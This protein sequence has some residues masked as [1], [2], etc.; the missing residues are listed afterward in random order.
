MG[1]ILI[2]LLCWRNLL[3]L[4]RLLM[5]DAAAGVYVTCALACVPIA[6]SSTTC[7]DAISKGIVPRWMH[8]E[9]P[10][11][12]IPAPATRPSLTSPCTCTSSSS[13]APCHALALAHHRGRS[14]RVNTRGRCSQWLT[15]SHS[16]PLNPLGQLGRP[17]GQISLCYISFDC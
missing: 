1:S 5:N 14:K 7:R 12:E 9:Q 16:R 2:M 13:C 4:R 11:R 8:T 17:W 6:P 15:V 3:W 10:E